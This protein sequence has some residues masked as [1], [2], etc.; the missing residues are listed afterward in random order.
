VI[1]VSAKLATTVIFKEG[2]SPFHPED[3]GSRFPRQVR[4]YLP[5]YM[6]SSSNI[7]ETFVSKIVSLE[8]LQII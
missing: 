1:L 6:A 3:A 4:T 7:S 8:F 5:S 2:Q